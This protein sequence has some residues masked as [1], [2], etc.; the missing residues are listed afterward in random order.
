MNDRITDVLESLK[1]MLKD[2]LAEENTGSPK[3][4]KLCD[5]EAFLCGLSSSDLSNNNQIRLFCRQLERLINMNINYSF[6]FSVWV[7]INEY[8][9]YMLDE[10]NN[11]QNRNIDRE[12]CLKRLNFEE[13]LEKRQVE[14]Q[15]NMKEQKSLYQLIK[16]HKKFLKEYLQTCIYF[17]STMKVTGLVENIDDFLCKNYGQKF[18]SLSQ[19][20]RQRL[21]EK[22]KCV[23]IPLDY[24][25]RSLEDKNSEF[26]TV[27]NSTKAIGSSTNSFLT[28]AQL[29]RARG[30]E[31]LITTKILKSERWVVI[32]GEPGNGKTTLLRSIM[33]IYADALRRRCKKLIFRRNNHT[34][35]TLRIP[36]LIRIGEFAS[37]LKNDPSNTRL[38]DYIGEHTWFSQRYCR[39]DSEKVLK[40][41]INHGHALILL[42]GLDEVPDVVRRE[43][44]VKSIRKF[45][46]E[47]VKDPNFVSAFDQKLFHDYALNPSLVETQPPGESGG[48][49]III[50]SRIVGYD[51]NSLVGTFIVHRLLPLMKEDEAVK[52]AMNWMSQVEHKILS[53]VGIRIRKRE[54]ESL[55]RRRIE[56]VKSIFGTGEKSL[57]FNSSL[58][59]SIFTTIFRSP[60]E[61]R[62]QSRVE[63]FTS[64]V[65]LALRS[66]TKH[67]PG[68]LPEL[69]S[70]FLINL[71][72]Y[73]HLKSS[74]GLIDTFD[75]TRLA[76]LTVAGQKMIINGN[77]LL[78]TLE[79]NAGIIAEHG[80]QVF[81]FQHLLFQEY[82]VAQ[83]LVKRHSIDRTTRSEYR[84]E[85][86]ANRILLNAINPRFREPILL[87]LGWI[88][89]Q[90]SI[91]EFDQ[92]CTEFIKSNK[93]YSI[94]LA[95]IL[96]FDAFK[97]MPR[98][99]SE[100]IIFTALDNLLD[101]PSNMI[102][103]TYFIPNLFKLSADMIEK[104]VSRPF[105]DKS[106]SK[107]CQCLLRVFEPKFKDR[108]L[109]NLSVD[110]ES[111][112]EEYS[113]EEYSEA[114]FSVISKQLYS[115]YNE[116][117][118]AKFIVDQTLRRIMMLEGV[119]DRTLPIHRISN[120]NDL[121][122][123][124]STIHPLILSIL[125]VVCG[126]VIWRDR[127]GSF[128]ID[129]S[130]RRMHRESSIVEPIIEYLRNQKQF[131]SN[132]VQTLIKKYKK[133][134]DEASPS[135]TSDDIV[136][137]FVA[138]I[139]LREISNCFIIKKYA[140]Y[141]ALSMAFGK[142]KQTYFL[143][144][145]MFYEKYADMQSLV[146]ILFKNAAQPI[147]EMFC[148]RS[149]RDNSTVYKIV[150]GKLFIQWPIRKYFFISF[151]EDDDDHLQSR[152][153][154]AHLHEKGKVDLNEANLSILLTFVPPSLQKLYYR[155]FINSSD[156]TDSLP[157]V[158]FLAQCLTYLEN[159]NKSHPD[160]A[161]FRT[162]LE[163][164]C[165]E[166]MLES[167]LSSL[168]FKNSLNNENKENRSKESFKATNELTLSKC[169][170][171][172][173]HDRW[174]KQ[175]NMEYQ[176]ISEAN[177]IKE[178]EVKNCRL[179]AA[180]ICL[181]QLFQVKYSSSSYVSTTKSEKVSNAIK[182]IC[183]PILRIIALNMVLEMKNPS[184]FD[185]KQRNDLYLKMIPPLESFLPFPRPLLKL[186]FMFVRFH[187]QHNDCPMIASMIEIIGERFRETSI[188]RD[189]HSREAVLDALQQLGDSYYLS[190]FFYPTEWNSSLLFQYF[191]NTISF[192]S[193]NTTFLSWLYV[194]ELAFDI[195]LSQMYT[196]GYFENQIFY[197]ERL[198]SQGTDKIMTYQAAI[199][200]TNY[201]Q[202]PPNKDVLHEVIRIML[203][204]LMVE[205]EALI[206]IERWL[207]YRDEEVFKIFAQYAALQLFIAYSEIPNLIVIINEIFST[208]DELHLNSFIEYIFHSRI[209][210]LNILSQILITWQ[211]NL[212]YSSNISIWINRQDILDLILDLEREQTTQNKTEP[213]QLPL[214]SF[215]SIIKGCSCDL[216][217]RLQQYLQTFIEQTSEMDD[218]LKERHVANVIQWIIKSRI[219][220]DHNE[221]YSKELYEYIFS[222]LG[223][224][225]YYQVQK[226]ILNALFSLFQSHWKGKRHALLKNNAIG[227]LETI[228]SSWGEYREDIL[229]VCL[230]SYGNYL[231]NLQRFEIPYHVSKKIQETL[232][233]LFE[234]SSTKISIRAGLCLITA[235]NFSQEIHALLHW[236]EKKGT[237]TVELKYEI[238][239]QQ[240]LFEEKSESF[241]ERSEI[242]DY[243]STHSA[244]LMNK[245]VRELNNDLDN[246]C[247]N[248]YSYDPSPDYVHIA[249]KFLEEGFQ[250]FQNFFQQ[251]SIDETTLKT[252]L[253][254]YA[255]YA[256]TT[257][258]Y[259]AAVTL[260][261]SFGILTEELCKMLEWAEVRYASEMPIYFTNI[262]EV[263][264]RAV[265]EILFKKL[266]L[267]MN[268]GRFE[269]GLF[270]LRLLVRLAHAD[271]VSS[272]EVHQQVTDIINKFS[273]NNKLPDWFYEESIWN[274]VLHLSQII[275][276][277][278]FNRNETKLFSES[279]IDLE[280]K[281]KIDQLKHSSIE[282]E[283]TRIT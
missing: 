169:I 259:E 78:E 37:W 149:D 18:L 208:D 44:I 270:I 82:F 5:I 204:C 148:P 238:L 266:K 81:G 54:K 207:T 226:A 156:K 206:I 219:W 90:W 166:H 116:G 274:E 19:K 99:P 30:D 127:D 10:P 256:K 200:I 195:H 164:Q 211:K 73:L 215:L 280:F 157:L 21:E 115:V 189:S 47:Y 278:E 42:D 100:S 253:R 146:K 185:E 220:N 232:T 143:I 240:T 283:F 177:N 111:S 235:E 49:Q 20:K 282:G 210:D 96:L 15:K 184:I 58:L 213:S 51:M 245:F 144:A 86:I 125:I 4:R 114:K 181:A 163:S 67:K 162:K 48:N 80:L 12:V 231:R 98:S 151:N 132:K 167:Y 84:I 16:E 7:Q 38:I 102:V 34:A 68:I 153:Q 209:K 129:W 104:W 43:E 40:E 172:D 113:D 39:A 227:H 56:A 119:P 134:I 76:C 261:G 77:Q 201:L 252:K 55:L 175:I 62:P 212:Y 50:T 192:D 69:L 196:E 236:F 155:L 221:N 243:T 180:S 94:P 75:I 33:R 28:P 258:D 85:E 79:S 35:V 97:D 272:S 9:I 32:L 36:V 161:I 22:F 264:D 246:K 168:L 118:S 66:W 121:E 197:L 257:T 178:D 64:I 179:F 14:F 61:F 27:I 241:L 95:A 193:T 83:S 281:K 145:R 106:L 135:D 71:S 239:L 3:Y 191:T 154:F 186:T 120:L 92:F 267:F 254:D 150:L 265:I 31:N 107:F 24:L 214:K 89:W 263:S 273:L 159:V 65:D 237:L 29:E 268:N 269:F 174:E 173:P 8:L 13:E 74:F 160:F 109:S 217:I 126:G 249:N 59:S 26:S 46:C 88:S 52:F 130:Y 223:H 140:T 203:E 279:D 183:D 158:V 262:N 108:S 182:N 123:N 147:M 199:W 11:K 198:T 234:S 110:S 122:I 170:N 255:N 87:A 171:I 25:D 276:M 233:E 194:T 229:A 224:R 93:N 103:K 271:V 60:D 105:N 124:V 91:D 63:M 138:L 218:I 41:F 247:N 1:S 225:S 2:K 242:A 187:T 45:I 202:Q 133:V 139:C 248:Y 230:L 131:H 136:D 117:T 101:H 152:L 251:G 228:I 53:R 137:T 260:Y 188:D 244:E 216:Q 23:E 222:F 6:K 165:K 17:H 250:K 141:Q 190:K 277:P 205:K 70:Q 112:D 128:P 275:N 176:R 72:T 142:I 57:T